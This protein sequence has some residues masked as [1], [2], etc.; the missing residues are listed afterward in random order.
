MAVIGAAGLVAIAMPRPP[1][2]KPAPASHKLGRPGREPLGQR[3]PA[4]CPQARA[5]HPDRAARHTALLVAIS[6]RR[7]RLRPRQ[8]FLARPPK[9][10]T[11]ACPRSRR[12]S[13]RPRS[14]R[15]G[16]AGI[17]VTVGAAAATSAPGPAASGSRRITA[18]AGAASIRGDDHAG[19]AAADLAVRAD[20]VRRVCGEAARRHRLP[21]RV[22]S[23]PDRENAMAT[24]KPSPW[25]R[26]RTIVQF[27]SERK[28]Q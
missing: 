15:P 13:P 5:D 2:P 3:P 1:A 28:K 7:P 26:V 9:S 4:G 24:K 25:P 11:A 12:R 16:A 17:G 19:A 18:K 22:P 14:S 10:P 20:R 8:R 23:L 21:G 27:V 6:C